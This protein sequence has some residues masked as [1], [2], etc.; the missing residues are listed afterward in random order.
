MI[1]WLKGEKIHQ[2]ERA[3]RAGL[4]LSCNGIGFEIQIPKRI[5]NSLEKSDVVV[6]WVHE[7][8]KEEGSSLFGFIDL[9]ERDLFRKLISVSGVG[10]QLAISL[11]EENKY[12]Q[13]IS[14]ILN[15][16][17]SELTK[18]T[19][20]GKRTAERLV[21]ELKNKLSEFNQK[22]IPKHSFSNLNNCS[23]SFKEELINEVKSA[24]KNLEYTESEILE[25]LTTVTRNYQSKEISNKGQSFPLQSIDFDEIFKEALTTLQKEYG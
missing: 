25:A 2:W 22:V 1:G 21:L 11:I 3:N 17:I 15:S 8:N 24:L 19:G 6:L 5:L 20:V 14:A 4:I 10:P 7:I 9:V 13:L 23:F 16:E 12:P 18:C